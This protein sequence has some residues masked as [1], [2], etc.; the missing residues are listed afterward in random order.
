MRALRARLK[1]RRRV[2]VRDAKFT[3]V[4]EDFLSLPKGKLAIKLQAISC[5]RYPFHFP[6]QPPRRSRLDAEI[7]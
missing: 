1:E 7:F 4:I 5:A 6:W 3:E 2:N